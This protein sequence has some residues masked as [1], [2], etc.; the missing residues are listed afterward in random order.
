MDEVQ[1]VKARVIAIA[2]SL[3]ARGKVTGSTANVSF[4]HEQRVFISRTNSSFESLTEAD[5]CKMDLEGNYLSGPKASKEYPLHLSFYRANPKI[6]AIIHTHSFY[7]TLWAS[8][9]MAK[10]IKNIPKFTPYLEMKLGQVPLLSY[11]RPGSEELFSLFKNKVR[12][13]NKAYLLANHGVIV[14]EESIDK[15]Y[16]GL[17]ELEETCRIAWELRNEDIQ[18]IQ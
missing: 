16:Y 18:E 13:E 10:N 17:E 3:F 7:S 14:G 2:R 4:L 12:A 8:Y 11:E 15:A 1:L 6:Q 9:A 5:F